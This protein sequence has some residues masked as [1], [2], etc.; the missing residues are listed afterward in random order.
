LN[1]NIEKTTIT[2]VGITGP[3]S[4]DLKDI[5]FTFVDK[6]KLLGL[7]ISNN[8]QD[9]FQYF[10]EAIEKIRNIRDFWEK[11]KLNLPGRISIAKTFMLSQKATLAQ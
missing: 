1:C 8:I 11:L 3:P 5:G 2:L 7:E 9:R 4:Q 10:D 6:F